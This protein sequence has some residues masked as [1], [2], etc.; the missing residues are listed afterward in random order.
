MKDIYLDGTLSECKSEVKDL[1]ITLD[2]KLLCNRY[3]AM[4]TIKARAVMIC[5]KI[6]GK[7]RSP[8]SPGTP[9]AGV[10]I[11]GAMR[12]CPTA[13]LEPHTPIHSGG[14]GGPCINVQSNRGEGWRRRD[15]APENLII[16]SEILPSSKSA[17][18]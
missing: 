3:I 14:G 15:S 4:A 10:C 2:K 1:G 17:E 11:S 7:T 9:L 5:K 8:K 18:R 13:T 12:T 16:S 6:P